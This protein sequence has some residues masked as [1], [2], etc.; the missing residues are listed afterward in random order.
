MEVE[1]HPK[2]LLA[3]LP[4]V[5]SLTYSNPVCPKLVRTRAIIGWY[6]GS[7]A[8][9]TITISTTIGRRNRSRVASTL[10]SRIQR[11][12]KLQEPGLGLDPRK[13]EAWNRSACR[14]Y[15]MIL[16]LAQDHSERGVWGS[17]GVT[18]PS[19]QQRS[20][21]EST[22]ADETPPSDLA[23][24]RAGYSP[25]DA[26]IPGSDQIRLPAPRNNTSGTGFVKSVR[27]C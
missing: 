23:P 12:P 18:R 26:D 19:P 7:S 21:S 27:A 20:T 6:N 11:L 13:R 15:S 22:A 9:C 1:V 17:A 16:Y 2:S 3:R 10:S 5:Q 4:S 25:V 14:S 24:V 8:R